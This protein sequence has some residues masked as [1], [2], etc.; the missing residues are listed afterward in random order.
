MPKSGYMIFSVSNNVSISEKATKDDV[1]KCEVT[2]PTRRHT[3]RLPVKTDVMT[4]E[5]GGAT[6][7]AAN[8]HTVFRLEYY[9]L[10]LQM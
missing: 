10:N 9:C 4:V 7:K 1:V 6:S 5:G 3:T 2:C 8:K